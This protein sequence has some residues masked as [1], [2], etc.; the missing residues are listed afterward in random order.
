M[1]NDQLAR[2]ARAYPD[3]ALSVIEQSGYPFSVRCRVELDAQREVVRLIGDTI[4]AMSAPPAGAAC[5]AFHR[6]DDRLEKQYQLLI[7]GQLA[8][9]EGGLILRPTAFVTANGS[10]SHDRMPHAGAPLD[11]LRFMLLGRKQARAYLRRR[12][13]PWPPIDFTP[14]L[15]IVSEMRGGG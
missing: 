2:C 3:A 5:L 10:D 15:R 12:K 13:A 11:I 7:R 14:M 4:E 8:L 1:W 9:G 6:H